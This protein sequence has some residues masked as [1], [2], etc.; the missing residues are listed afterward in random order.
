MITLMVILGLVGVLVLIIQL[1]IYIK[2]HPKVNK[3]ALVAGGVLFLLGTGAVG[4]KVYKTATATDD[5]CTTA[6]K[7]N[8]KEPVSLEKAADYLSLGNFH[9]E[10]GGCMK[11]ILDYTKALYIE[12][13]YA[14]AFN[15]RAYTYMR[16]Q[17][18][19]QAL[20][21][22]NKALKIRPNYINALMNRGD[23]YNYYGPEIDKK[24]AV[25]DYEKV[26][27]L[28]GAKGTSVCGHKAMAEAN[29]VLPVAFLRVVAGFNC[30]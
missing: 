15:N 23:L 22:L 17:N 24:S 29:G 7:T 28:G 12:P 19:S 26:I 4:L 10:T 20:A 6:H 8:L 3:K 18:Y 21:D 30:R 1:P 2:K 11:A 13:N 5:Q 14:E 27:S 9:Y 16:M 25:K